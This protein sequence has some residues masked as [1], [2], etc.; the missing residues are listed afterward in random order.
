M[1]TLLTLGDEKLR[2]IP[3]GLSPLSPI[4][5]PVSRFLDTIAWKRNCLAMAVLYVLLCV[6]AAM[7]AVSTT[8]PKP[9]GQKLHLTDYNNYVIFK[10][11]FDHLLAEDSLYIAYP[12]EH[13]DLFKYSPTFALAFG[14]FAFLP[15]WLG[16]LLWALLNALALW[17]G[18]ARLPGI[19]ASRKNLALLLC[20]VELMTSLQ[21][22]QSNGLIA[23]FIILAVSLLER[24]QYFWATLLLVSTVFVKLF[25]IVAFC[26]LLLYPGKYRLFLY[27]LFWTLVLA[28]LP[29]LVSS[30]EGYM[31]QLETYADM[32]GA[33]HAGSYGH[34]LMG[35]M[36]R[37]FGW[38]GEKLMVVGLGALVMMSPFLLVRRYRARGFRYRA[39]AAVLMWVVI[40]NHK[41]ESPTFIIAM[42]GMALWF[43]LSRPG[44]KKNI[45]LLFALLLTSL[46]STDLFP[47]E[48]R[49][50]WITAF[51]LKALPPFVIWLILLWEMV[52][53]P[54][55]GLVM[56]EV[57]KR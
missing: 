12:D 27:S 43:V 26:L 48:W 8:Q 14:A 55:K 53:L 23:G 35:M 39:M 15:D 41:A 38:E 42:A 33:D 30:P 46:S 4:F 21:N 2:D 5:C 32:L 10:Q 36:H 54:V 20:A 47:S 34:S 7:Q 57:V 19:S 11:S 45:L 31:M 17:C 50:A 13:W 16:L 44:W 6:F 51:S 56:R 40:F 28:L 24:R 22:E 49:K 1:S 3:T 18:L 29:L 9:E 25:G 37:I 52:R